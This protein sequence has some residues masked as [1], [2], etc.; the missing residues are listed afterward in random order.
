MRKSSLRS[1]FLYRLRYYENNNLDYARKRWVVY[2][3]TFD[4]SPSG[5]PPE[6]HGWLEGVNDYAGPASGHYVKPIYSV[7]SAPSKT[8]TSEAYLPKGSWFN[9]NKR[10]WKKFEAWQPSKA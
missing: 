5:I 4:Y 10:N 9:S 6:W 8:G 3:D 2:A 7:L 1:D